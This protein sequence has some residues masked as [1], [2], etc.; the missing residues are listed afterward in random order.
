MDENTT[1]LPTTPG[2]HDSVNF[3]SPLINSLFQ[4]LFKNY[5]LLLGIP[6]KK[7]LNGNH[8]PCSWFPERN[9]SQD[10]RFGRKNY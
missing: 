8:L 1:D 2:L 9:L 6:T 5:E 3:I 7:I 10:A 4:N